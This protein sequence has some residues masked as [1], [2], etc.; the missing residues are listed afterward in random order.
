MRTTDVKNAYNLRR[1]HFSAE[2]KLTDRT[3]RGMITRS[4]LN[5]DL[6]AYTYEWLINILNKMDDFGNLKLTNTQKKSIEINNWLLNVSDNTQW[7][8]NLKNPGRLTELKAELESIDITGSELQELFK[9][10]YSA[11]IK[12][13]L[14]RL[15]DTLIRVYIVEDT[16]SLLKELISMLHSFKQLKP[17]GGLA[18]HIEVLYEIYSNNQNSDDPNPHFQ[19][20]NSYANT[21]FVWSQ[22][23]QLM[24]DYMNSIESDEP[25]SLEKTNQSLQQRM[26]QIANRYK[27][28]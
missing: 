21:T 1:Q 22:C 24:L 4:I 12:L 27:T 17:I 13:L 11:Y 10:F 5:T 3:T 20:I 14:V 25:I 16:D 23:A 9:F 8:T 7:I 15:E 18:E 2:Y 26:E 19:F 6:S 28:F